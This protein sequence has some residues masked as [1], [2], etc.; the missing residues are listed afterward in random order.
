M[1]KALSRAA[2]VY[3]VFNAD[4][5][6]SLYART[7]IRLR[8]RHK[9]LRRNT[10]NERPKNQTFSSLH[11]NIEL[12]IINCCLQLQCYQRS[13]QVVARCYSESMEDYT[14]VYIGGQCHNNPLS[15]NAHL[16]QVNGQHL[17]QNINS[18]SSKINLGLNVFQ[19]K[20]SI[21]LCELKCWQ[22]LIHRSKSK[23]KP[24]FGQ[25]K[26]FSNYVYDR[27]GKVEEGVL[28]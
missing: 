17:Q 23:P 14:P 12:R 11:I 21:F 2:Q 16:V 28:R 18:V 7:H 27:F 4:S 10:N 15:N 13:G 19:A 20:T 26:V 24:V 3:P 9:Y 22:D 25:L 6:Q 8:R 1:Y 5:H